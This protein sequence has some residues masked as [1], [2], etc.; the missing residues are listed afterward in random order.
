VLVI[1]HVTK[2]LVRIPGRAEAVQPGGSAFYVAAALSRLGLAVEVLTRVAPADDPELLEPLRALGVRVRNLPTPSTTLFE[3]AYRDPDLRRRDQ[4]VLGLAA[5]FSPADLEGRTARAIHLGPLT[6]GELGP[7][8]IAAARL[9]AQH[10]ALD[11]QGLMRRLVPVGDGALGWRVEPTRWSDADRALALVDVLK[12]DDAEAEALVGVRAPEG[13]AA[14]LGELGVKEVLITFADRGSLLHVD[15]QSHPIPA[16]APRA[17]VDAT[18]CGDT[19]SAGYLG[20]RL[21]GHAPLAAARF[22]AIIA[23]AKLE[24]R[25]PF[26]GDATE[27]EARLASW[28]S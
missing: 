27:L 24:A 15:G 10:L 8:V 23:S 3:N 9:R 25:G 19:Y 14:R 20:R 1:G 17:V 5:P 16:A 2:D 28:R 26:R 11:G 18:G 7:G 13:A 21:A 4:R 22:A 12:V 6:Q